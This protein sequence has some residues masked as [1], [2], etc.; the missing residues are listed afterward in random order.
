MPRCSST[1]TRT[2]TKKTTTRPAN[3]RRLPRLDSALPFDLGAEVYAWFT[4]QPVWRRS[5][6]QLASRLPDQPGLRVVD[7]GCGP[8]VSTLELAR[9]RPTDRLCGLDLAGRMLHEAQRR[10]ARERPANPP[11]WVRADAGH[12]PLRSSSVDVL[13]GH[14]FLYLLGRATQARALPEMLRVLRPGGRVVLMEPSA[15]PARLKQVLS[16]SQ[17]P[18]HLVSI[19]LWRPYSR[20]HGRFTADRLRAMFEQHGFVEPRVE[21]VLAGLGLLVSADA[22]RV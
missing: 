7:L 6:A 17:D 10:A 15:Q 5:C 13:T 16:L 21:P 22:P 11:T 20:F 2:R 12:L 8:G 18:R 9:R 1:R 14:S 4:Y 19:A 3:G